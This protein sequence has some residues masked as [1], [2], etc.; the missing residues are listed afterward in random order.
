MIRIKLFI[1]LLV[2]GANL[3]GFTFLYLHLKNSHTFTSPLSSEFSIKIQSDTLTVEQIVEESYG[4]LMGQK[5]VGSLPILDFDTFAKQLGVSVNSNVFMDDRHSYDNFLIENE[6]IPYGGF[7]LYDTHFAPFETP[8]EVESFL[9]LLK[10]RYK[11]E[12]RI[13]TLGK[14]Y[15]VVVYPFIA[16]DCA[17]N[18]AKG[19]CRGSELLEA[20]GAN[21]TK[22]IFS[23]DLSGKLKQYNKLASVY[24]DLGMNTFFSPCLDL[25]D[26]D[27]NID[28]LGIYAKKVSLALHEKRMIPT[29]KHFAYT[30]KVDTHNGSYEENRS[31]EEIEKNDLKPYRVVEELGFPY[32]IM[33][34]HFKLMAI[35]DK[36]ICTKS[37]KVKTYISKNFPNAVTVSDAI[38]MK[39]YSKRDDLSKRITDNICDVV[40]AKTSNISPTTEIE[41][42]Y[43]AL[44]TL[45]TNNIEANKE[46]LVKILRLKQEYGLLKIYE[47]KE[48]I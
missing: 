5:I 40:I 37:Q 16:T 48:A 44:K 32:M 18:V 31:L 36:E 14:N 46:S 30:A 8:K 13:S 33:P 12:L 34:T 28:S 2:V 24:N 27:E 21:T 39:G 9:A 4:F 41:E 42:I 1:L 10:N 45:K 43:K 17:V 19:Y 25:K 7:I 26:Y 3:L 38:D 6:E 22:D 29:L 47:E 15:L 20:S 23:D 11:Q 35:D